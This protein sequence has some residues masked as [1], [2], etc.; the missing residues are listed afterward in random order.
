MH[1]SKTTRGRN[2]TP[3]NAKTFDPHA[4]KWLESDFIDIAISDEEGMSAFPA[5]IVTGDADPSGGRGAKGRRRWTKTVGASSVSSRAVRWRW[6]WRKSGSERAPGGRTSSMSPPALGNSR[7]SR[8]L[9]GVE[10]SSVWDLE[11]AHRETPPQNN[12]QRELEDLRQEIRD[13]RRE[14]QQ[15]SGQRTGTGRGTGN[16]PAIV[17]MIETEEVGMLSS[18]IEDMDYVD[19]LQWEGPDPKPVD[20]RKRTAVSDGEVG[21]H[22][23]QVKHPTLRP[24]GR[25]HQGRAIP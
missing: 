12:M 10:P 14:R 1:L 20:N 21:E 15:E 19:V 7:A 13:L 24:V 4:Q 9:S 17:N 22:R 2:S 23:P 18:A 6:K 25:G 5:P 8:N 11:G 16:R 3:T